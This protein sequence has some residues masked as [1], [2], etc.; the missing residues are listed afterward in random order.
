MS[1]NRNNR[2]SVPVPEQA[3]AQAPVVPEVEAAPVVEEVPPVVKPIE[4]KQL[5]PKKSGKVNVVATR[6]GYFKG[7]RKVEGDKF[8]LDDASEMGD[9]MKKI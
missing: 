8:T 2:S 4:E 5:S 1:N 6:N 7:S 9:W 3:E